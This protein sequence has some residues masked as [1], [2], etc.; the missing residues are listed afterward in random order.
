VV[1]DA[2]RVIEQGKHG[3]LLALDGLYSHLLANQ[4]VAGGEMP[5][6]AGAPETSHTSG[7][8]GHGHSHA[9]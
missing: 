8:L 5:V 2:G 1:L 9:H 3:E 6:L 7:A 4:L